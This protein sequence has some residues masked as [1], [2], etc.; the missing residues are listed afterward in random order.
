MTKTSNIE[1]WRVNAFTDKPFTGN[2]AG[3]VPEA[4]G[5]SE[6]LMQAIAAEVN[7]IS[8]TVFICRPEVEDADVQLRYFTSTT[9]VDLCG[10][11]TIAALFTLS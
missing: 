2:P 5:L 8:E 7:D 6:A 10:Y 11:A 3:V 4:D 9:E 1:V